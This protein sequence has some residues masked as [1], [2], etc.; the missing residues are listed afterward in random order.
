VLGSGFWVNHSQ[1]ASRQS[2]SL[3]TG[4]LFNKGRFGARE[5]E[6]LVVSQNYQ[7]FFVCSYARQSVEYYICPRS[8]R[9]STT[10]WRR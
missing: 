2:L 3:R 1:R 4:A 7:G 6:A 5:H 8:T 10:V 9:S